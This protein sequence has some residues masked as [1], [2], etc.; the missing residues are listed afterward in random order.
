MKKDANGKEVAVCP[1]PECEPGGPETL[2]TDTPSVSVLVPVRNESRYID[3]TLKQLLAQDYDPDRFEVIVVDGE[4]TD[5][6]CEQVQKYARRYDNVHLLSNPR[7]LS[8]SARNIGIRQARGDIVL[9]V[10]GHCEAEDPQF[11]RKLADAFTVSGA[12]C[13]GRP[14]PLDTARASIFQRAVAAARHSLLGHHPSSYVYSSK[15]RFVPATSVA[16]AYRRD[17]FSEIGY[18]DEDFDAC[19]DVELNYRL[20]RAGFRC[21]FAPETAVHYVPRRSLRDVF[22]QMMRYG[23]GRARLLRKH[24]STFSLKTLAPSLFL[25]TCCAGLG[26]SWLSFWPAAACFALLAVYATAVLA[27]SLAIAVRRRDSKILPR[28]P[29]VFAAIHAGAGVGIL[30]GLLVDPWKD[31][32]ARRRGAAK[33]G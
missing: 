7:L 17:V 30:W 19:E 15:P 12:D 24:P 14:Q 11:I 6:T 33:G 2:R 1:A 20:D 26:L 32:F 22:C 27:A 3:R 16:V 4:S 10:D 28:L 8:S 5:D 21:Y 31:R 25:L 9:I 29:A 23:Q 13:V 18:F